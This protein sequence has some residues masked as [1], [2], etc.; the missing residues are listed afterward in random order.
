MKQFKTIILCFILPL[1]FVAGVIFFVNFDSTKKQSPTSLQKSSSE[2]QGSGVPLVVK[3]FSLREFDKSRV[4]EIFIKAK[5]GRLSKVSDKI[6]CFDIECWLKNHGLDAAFLA[7]EH[8]VV[9]RNTKKFFL[10]GPVHGNLQDL[11][12][13][14]SDFVYDFQ[15]Q[16]IVTKKA[17]KLKHPDFWFSS[18]QSEVDLTSDEIK[19]SGGVKTEISQSSASNNSN[20]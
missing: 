9:K 6:D 12:V 7:A 20:N 2:E 16:K 8:S 11:E 14:G 1:I 3:G 19:M 4:Y 15:T 10:I 5:E 18:E 13:E 17:M